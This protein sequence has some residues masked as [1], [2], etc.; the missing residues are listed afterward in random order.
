MNLRIIFHTALPA[1]SDGVRLSIHNGEVSHS[2][3][4]RQDGTLKC[5]TSSHGFISIQSC[6]WFLAKYFRNHI[7]QRWDTR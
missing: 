2:E 3:R 6:A 1:Q 7:L 5:T 4:W